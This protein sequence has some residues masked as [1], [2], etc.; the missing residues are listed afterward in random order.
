MTVAQETALRT[1][2]TLLS[3]GH[4]LEQILASSL[5]PSELHDFVKEEIERDTNIEFVPARL[6]VAD[7]KRPDWILRLDRSTWYYWP[8]LRLLLL[9]KDWTTTALRSLDDSSDMI[10]RQL[11]PPETKTFDVRGLVLGFVQSGKTANFTAVAAKAVDAGYRL[12][13]VLSGI[14]KGLRRQTNIRLENELVGSSDNRPDAVPLPPTG[15]QWFTF[16]RPELEGDF[17]PGNANQ[18]ALQGSQPILMVLKKNGAVLRRLLG[19]LDASP[20]ELRRVI[21]VLIVDDEAD[22]AS[23]DVKGSYQTE[24]DLPDPDWEPPS[25]INGLIR[26]LLQRFDRKAYVAYTATPFA[27]ILIPH[28]TAYPTFGSDLYPIDFIVDLPK[29][30]GYF[31]AE[32]I[33]G[34]MDRAAGEE[35]EGLDVIRHVPDV[36]LA[37]LEEGQLPDSLEI[38]MLD[39]VLAGSGRVQREQRPVPATMLVHTDRLIAAQAHLHGMVSGRFGELRD[40][41]R[42]QRHETLRE[43]LRLRWES[44]FQPTTRSTHPDK[45]VSFEEVEPHIGPFFEA[46]QV[47]QVNSGAGEVL[48]YER[49]PLL[50]AIAIG[51][52]KLSRG[53]TWRGFKS[54]TSSERARPTT[55]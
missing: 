32:E 31:G 20:A 53:L 25:I 55:L 33:F 3:L 16:T 18:A 40:E 54:A 35:L 24:E 50:K 37:A 7:S 27:N 23:V 4:A 51:G 48:D 5:I 8:L 39:F 14:D 36:D 52:N 15:K 42:Y 49:E 1:V 9:R 11:P 6:L 44:E 41:W 47:R 38:A 13:I 19:W 43:R 2:R 28:D 22:L 12:V 34:R 10:L 45:D 30:N 29:P 46:V 17:L 21:P 26:D